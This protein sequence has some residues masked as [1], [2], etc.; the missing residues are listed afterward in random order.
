[1]MH[2]GRSIHGLV[3]ERGEL[4][5]DGLTSMPNLAGLPVMVEFWQRC[6][7]WLTAR[8]YTLYPERRPLAHSESGHPGWYAPLSSTSGSFPYATCIRQN[9]QGVPR[10]PPS[11]VAWAQDT[12]S[13]DIVL[14]LVDTD[15]DEY[16]IYQTLL[17]C[18]EL[19]TPERN[20]GVLPPLAILDTP[21]RYSIV[22]MPMWGWALHLRE[23]DNI[24]DIFQFMRC[25]LQVTSLPF[26][27]YVYNLFVQG[28]CVLHAH[29]IAHR[30]IDTTNI[31]INCYDP[32]SE[33]ALEEVVAEHRRSGAAA[34]CLFDFNLSTQL[35]SDTSLR[36]CRR[37]AIEALTAMPAYMPND[38]FLG[39]PS[40]NPFA[41]DVGC[42]G[43]LFRT[44]FWRAASI[45]PL[46]APLFDR[47][48]THNLTRRFTAEEALAFL[49]YAWSQLPES[50]H[51]ACLSSEARKDHQIQ[52]GMHW[53]LTPP[54]FE[55]QW[56]HYKT[57]PYG[58]AA[59]ILDRAL[60]QI[61]QAW[62]LVTFVRKM[63]N[64]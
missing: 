30:D 9:I 42:L 40:Y 22:A 43:N 58:W 64:T 63:L 52:H 32:T 7:P 24:A 33:V 53:S 12:L 46:L 17:R 38:T 1:M 20:P 14:K 47:M 56:S 44:F 27:T 16:S 28:L 21:F 11:R 26:Y 60:V 55:D 10:W 29:R 15:S 34:Y 45:M 61:P 6:R 54:G 37:P 4:E 51:D 59:R 18:K 35:P 2:D 36:H 50:A 3:A 39:E 49:D 23:L 62:P 5:I 57:P 41:F 31:L 13:R 8:G 25:T 48:T 19:S